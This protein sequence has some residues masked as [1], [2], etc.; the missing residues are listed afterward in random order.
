MQAAAEP[1]RSAV[2]TFSEAS[3]TPMV[4]TQPT[5]RWAVVSLTGSVLGWLASLALVALAERYGEMA[6]RSAGVGVIWMGMH[7]LLAAALCL[8]GVLF[9]LVALVRVRSG[10][11]GGRGLAWTGI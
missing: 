3:R 4:D 2:W 7:L 6:N 8:L 11:C 1:G 9:G 10:E 5:T